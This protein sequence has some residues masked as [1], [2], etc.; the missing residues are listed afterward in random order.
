[1]SDAQ[2][3]DLRDGITVE[4]VAAA[5]ARLHGRIRRTPVMEIGRDELVSSHSPFA[6]KLELMQHTGAFKARGAMNSILAAHTIPEAGV[7]AASGGN[8]G[9]AVA[10]AAR[11]LG[12]PATIYVPVTC[13]AVKLR[14][15]ASYRAA[16][17]VIGDVYDQSLVSAIEF[18]EHSGALLIHPFDQT[19]TVAGAATV[20]TEFLEQA[21]DLDTILVPVGGGGLMAG[22]LV[23]TSG[24]TTNIVAV[25]PRSARC[26]GA[27]LEAGH[28]VDV[29]VSG[30]AVDSLGPTKAGQIAFN[31]ALRHHPVYVD[32]TDDDIIMAQRAAWEE[33]RVGVEG[34]GATA[35]AAVLGGAY[36][37]ADGERIG[38]VASGGNVDVT[39]LA[40]T[41][42]APATSCARVL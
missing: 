22:A 25:E 5:K 19:T 39:K 29:Q 24:S 13:P 6:L 27:A 33:L 1:M 7:C 21:P 16:V 37:P 3:R 9:Q 36:S 12:I 42:T 38:V 11:S 31:A 28:L 10:W 18:S 23:A 8:H 34:G 35:L 26:L 20:T 41:N 15:L 4:D 30:P 14:R 32:V 17:H 40:P 2:L